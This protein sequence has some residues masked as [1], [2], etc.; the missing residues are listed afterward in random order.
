MTT[1]PLTDAVEQVSHQPALPAL[2]LPEYHGRKPVG[3]KTSLTGTATRIT[4][5][6]SIGDRAV[7]VL[8][9]KVK[10]AGHED[11]DDGLTYAET[12]K[13]LDMFELSGDQGSRLISTVR[14]L[15]RTAED[16]VKG[17]APVPDLG[18]VGYTDGAGVVLT[19]AEVAELR[20]D[21]VR[22]ILSSD[23]QPAVVVYSDGARELWPDDF[24][25]DAPRPA[26]GQIFDADGTTV[27]VE[28]L[29][30]HETGEDLAET[31]PVSID[32]VQDTGVTIQI[33]DEIAD[34]LS[35]GIHIPHDDD[36]F[37][38]AAS[39]DDDIDAWEDPDPATT[40]RIAEAEADHEATLPTSADFALVDQDVKHLP[41]MAARVDDLAA[42]RRL[43]R[44][45][46]QGRGRGLKPRKGALVILENRVAALEREEV[47]R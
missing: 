26:I 38:P 32:P 35:H 27:A 13:V 42:A 19:P 18:D 1:N 39:L 44:A 10:K 16:A 31:A 30:H 41:D 23:L 6:H 47:G 4:R 37:S 11:T 22:A 43:V 24:P 36:P 9:V 8:E 40:E 15:H 46:E 28:R 3:M 7:L 14:S 5:P 20:G 21:P 33:P 25:R 12:L 2:E 34:E 29:L 45:E 17:R